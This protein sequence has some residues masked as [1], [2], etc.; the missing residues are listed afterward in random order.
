[1][2]FAF[3]SNRRGLLAL[4]LALLLALAPA[5]AEARAGSGLSLG[6]RGARTYSA[7]PSTTT[8]PRTASPFDST[9]TPRANP[10]PGFGLPGTT[11]GGGLFSGGFGRGFLG[12][13]LGAGLI[14]MLFGSGFSGGLNGGMSILGLLLQLGL[15]FFVVRL[16]LNW[17]RNRQPSYAGAGTGSAFTGSGFGSTSAPAQRQL[18]LQP[19]DFSAFERLLGEVQTAYG[20]EDLP[21][22]QR[23]TTPE[24]ASY[25]SSGLDA[26]RQKGLINRLSGIRLEQGD[27][28]EAWTEGRDDYATVA[29]RYALIDVMEERATGRIVSGDP[30]V[31]TQVTEIWT[32][33]R[34]AGAGSDAW[35]L[36]AIQQAG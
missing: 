4:G 15:A 30:R 20:L 19:T 13:L 18:P 22:L 10:S 21:H 29:M 33:R 14:G 12:G 35:L 17:F 5:L 11:P 16:A 36:S 26:N 9:A 32:F 24:M 2:S 34:P 8:A 31:P 6:S 23:I 28:S 27:L 3:L 7:P 1:M 25:F